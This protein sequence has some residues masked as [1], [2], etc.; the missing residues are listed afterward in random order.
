MGEMCEKWG[1]ESI[2]KYGYSS[3]GVVMGATYPKRLKELRESMPTTFYTCA[4]IW[5]SR[6]R[7]QRRCLCF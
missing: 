7:G 4:G 3:V 6:W 5:I 1:K 2:G